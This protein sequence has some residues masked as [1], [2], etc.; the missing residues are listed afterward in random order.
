LDGNEIGQI[1][2][3]DAAKEFGPYMF[4]NH[5]IKGIYQGEFATLEK[6][7]EL[8]LFASEKNNVD[9][10]IKADYINPRSNFD[11][12]VVFVNQKSLGAIKDVKRV[13]PVPMDGSIKIY[14]EKE[15]PWGK[16]KSKE[17][18]VKDSTSVDLTVN[19]VTDELKN[20]IM[21]SINEYN[22][23]AI[24]AQT[25]VD[26]SKL[27]NATKEKLADYT[28]LI[29]NMRSN[30]QQYKGKYLKAE[31]DLDSF[32]AY[33]RNNSYF[34]Q[35]S[36]VESYESSY[37]RAGDANP[38]MNNENLGWTYKLIFEEGKWKISENSRSYSFNSKNKKTFD[39]N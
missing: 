10:S 38:R 24:E 8:E 6:E 37:F 12:A 32:Q 1:D 5:K 3:A 7:Q 4:G 21:K 22:Q 36:V 19:G 20:A 34:V 2:K 35:V 29:E 39:F 30:N 31:Y 15:F 27:V 9:I 17:V 18:T 25:S 14:A 28:K 26:A 11:D 16:V 23:S 13:G 33:L